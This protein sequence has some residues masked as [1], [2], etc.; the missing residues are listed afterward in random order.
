[1]NTPAAFRS[2]L[3]FALLAA[4]VALPVKT[5]GG[6]QVE[7]MRDDPIRGQRAASV[8]EPPAP[9]LPMDPLLKLPAD[10]DGDGPSFSSCRPGTAPA[11][12]R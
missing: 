12:R 6:F 2:G 5:L 10:D 9:P 8:P 7:A 11:P 3:V 1:M 4:P